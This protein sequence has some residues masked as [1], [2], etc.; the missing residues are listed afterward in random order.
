MSQKSPLRAARPTP[1]AAT[2]EPPLTP[3]AYLLGIVRDADAPQEIRQWAAAQAL[4]YCH[5]KLFAIDHT[6]DVTLRHE[7]VLDEP[8]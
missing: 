8:E 3:L 2:I 6:G 7:D 5:S 1:S 4:P